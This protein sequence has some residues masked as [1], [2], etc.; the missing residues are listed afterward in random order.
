M[1]IFKNQ[2]RFVDKLQT[3]MKPKKF[4]HTADWHLGKR[5]LEYSRLPEQIQV[6]EEIVS[7]A[8]SQEV[9]VVLIAGDLFDVF[10]PSHEAQELFYKT[11]FRLCANGSRP[12][13]AIAGN[14]DSHALIEAPLPLSRELGIFLIGVDQGPIEAVTNAAGIVIHSSESGIVQIDF[15]DGDKVD[16]I[17]APYANEVLLRT[18]LGDNNRQEELRQLLRSKWNRISEDYFRPMSIRIFVGH[19]FFMREGGE[20]EEEPE[21]ERSI[22]HVGGVD[23]LFTDDLPDGLNYAALGHLHRFQTVDSR[24]YPV[25]YSS[26]PLAYSFSEAHQEKYV[27][28]YDSNGNVNPIALREG[29]KLIRKRFENSNEALEWLEGNPNCYVEVTLVVEDSIDSAIRSALYKA[30]LRIVHLIPER[31]GERSNQSSRVGASDMNLTT[32]ELF[33]KYF[34]ART[35]NEINP[36]LLETFREIAANK[37]GDL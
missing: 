15:P 3:L 13:I 22:L 31:R 7:I 5:L 36:E 10:Q 37:G 6:M 21:G 35:G 2:R 4:L 9:D 29:Y 24:R 16:V 30:H 12:V 28:V 8:N 32:E 34:F 20:R 23:A 26:S 19:F 14:H 18:W 17:V 1:I 25:V 27:V 11:L 33:K